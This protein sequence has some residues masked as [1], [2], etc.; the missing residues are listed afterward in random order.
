M[1][2]RYLFVLPIL[3][4]LNCTSV[5]QHN[6][7][8]ENT[9]PV[10][11]LKDD[12]AFIYKKFQKL[13]PNLYWY[14]DKSKLDFKFDSLSQSITKPLKSFEFYKKIA[15]VIAEIRQ[16][17]SGISPD[18]KQQTKAETKALI[19]KGTG[20]FSQ[21]EFENVE[22]KMVVVKNNSYNKKIKI[23]SEVVAI[24]GKK[25]NEF[26]K[27][28]STFFASDG[29]NTTFKKSKTVKIFSKIY[30][31]END[32]Q[33]S[34][35]FDFK[36]NDSI[37]TVCIHRKNMDATNAKIKPV[38]TIIGKELRQK[39][40]IE[41][42]NP[43]T[44]L[45]NRNLNFMTQDS[46]IAV[47][48]I[49]SFSVGNS[50]VFY[51]NAFKKIKKFQ[52]KTLIIDLRDNPG[53][54]LSEIADLYGYL[55]DS[56]FVF[57]DTPQV[58]S[59][60]SLFSINYFAGPWYL[61]PFQLAFSPLFYGYLYFKVHRNDAGQFVYNTSA[62]KLKPKN[63]DSF[64]G[65]IYVLINGGS[66]SASCILSSNLKGSK[67]AFFVGQETGGAFNGTVAGQMPI[68]KLPHS[69]LK[70]RIG[71]ALIAPHFKTNLEGR[72]IFPDQEILPT[73][74]DKIKEIDPEMNWILTKIK[75]ENP[76]NK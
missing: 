9:I 39:N 22:D 54:R 41:G 38:K 28:Y 8:L 46:S 21:F 59:K 2:N 76:Q 6:E 65:K 56:S 16:G 10:E 75:L 32:I 5:K 18:A 74:E 63:A 30:T 27:Q 45:Y 43:L 35:F 60:T 23:G 3:F 29:Y 69:K 11:K 49:R 1:K 62:T 71:L 34:L 61:K 17:H 58:V 25:T 36:F 66:F 73:I 20:P 15:P 53:G 42:Y 57:I 13:H 51:E 47:L 19:K 40:K 31:Y 14:I 44:K 67:R 7:Q 70:A 24:N 12:V 33:D 52:S 26:I 68:V 50:N 48:K 72:G 37:K 4:F 55:A 64:G